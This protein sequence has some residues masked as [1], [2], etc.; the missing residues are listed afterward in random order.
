[1]KFFFISMMAHCL[2][3]CAIAESAQLNTYNASIGIVNH[4]NRYIYATRVGS[5]AG[6]HA[7][8]YSAGIANMCCVTLPLQWHSGLSLMVQ[9]D[10]PEGTR[11]I[12]K[13]KEVIVEKYGKPGSVYLHFFP[14]D[15]VRIV[16]T[17]WVGGSLKHP[18]Q[19]PDEPS[20]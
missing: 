16:V 3:A 17:D 20:N 14:N 10:M 18:I 9:W 5:D 2:S 1:M 15:E 4:T 12:W 8:R 13:K 11:H 6:G 19:P 7:A